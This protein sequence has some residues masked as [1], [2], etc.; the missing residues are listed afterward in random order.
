MKPNDFQPAV[1][2]QFIMF[3]CFYALTWMACDSSAVTS[4]PLRPLPDIDGEAIS[5]LGDTLQPPTMDVDAF[6][7]ADSLLNEV[8]DEYQDDSTDLNTIIWYG[9][10]LAYVGQFRKAI[11]I[12][13]HGIDMYPQ[14]PE[15]FRHRGH[16]FL[17]IRQTENAIHDLETSASLLADGDS[18]LEPDGIPN[19]L[20]IP[21]SNLPFNVYYHLG[22]AWYIKA[23]FQ[24]AT[25]AFS[26][27]MTYA[28]NPDLKVAGTYWLYLTYLRSGERDAASQ[29]LQ[30][31]SRDMEIIENDNYLHQLLVFKGE[32][33]PQVWSDTTLSKQSMVNMYGISCWHET[34]GR[35]QD[36]AAW[37]RQILSTG[38]WPSFG[39]LAAEADSARLL[40]K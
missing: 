15:L 33:K 9:R 18:A 6:L 8:A 23:D 28:D 31:I 40:N 12:F 21:L 38:M 3:F 25:T 10:R 7:H 24:K 2:C 22:L 30:P 35:L 27:A 4:F 14:S 34:N 37:R 36:A 32:E 20:G 1:P 17:T 11:D 13:T 29:L 39:Y 5:F 16:R 26:S 19:K